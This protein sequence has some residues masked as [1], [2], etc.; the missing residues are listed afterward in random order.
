MTFGEYEWVSHLGYILLI[1]MSLVRHFFL[2]R[3]LAI[4]SGVASI[5]YGLLINSRPDVLWETIFT[6]INI[7]Q[8][9]ILVRENRQVSF[10]PEE[11]ELHKRMF[12]QLPRIEFY[13]LLRKGEWLAVPTGEELTKQGHEVV[14]IVLITDGTAEVQ[15]DGKVVAYCRQGD[16]VGEMAFVSGNPASATVQTI[17]PVRYLMWRFEDLRALLEQQADIRTAMQTVFNR[18]LIDKLARDSS[19]A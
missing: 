7:V 19:I 4:A 10:T 3:M 2:L 15:I 17:S 14:R 8:A 16:F 9:I 13:K 1:G 6:V 18:N 12:P 11:L 5:A